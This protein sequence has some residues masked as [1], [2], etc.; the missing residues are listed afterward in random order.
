MR[1][2]LEAR[3]QSTRAWLASWGDGSNW[4]DSTGASIPITKASLT[5]LLDLLQVSR[6]AL[7]EIRTLN[8]TRA[9]IAT[10][11]QDALDGVRR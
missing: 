8:L 2:N 5:E 6:E 11:A 10:I 7:R 1:D 3:L 9:T 4:M